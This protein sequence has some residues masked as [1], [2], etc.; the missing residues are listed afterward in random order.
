MNSIDLSWQM[1]RLTIW[2]DAQKDDPGLV[3]RHLSH[4]PFEDCY[5]TINP[6][7]QSPYPSANPNN[8]HLRGCAEGDTGANIEAAIALF[9][10]HGVQRFF[11]RLSPGPK[12]ETMR[13]CLRDHGMQRF[14]GTGYP[15][16]IRE[17]DEPASYQTAFNVRELSASD[18]SALTDALDQTIG[19]DQRRTFLSTVSKPG[20]YHFA[21]FEDALPVAVGVLCVLGEMGYLTNGA[22][23][24]RYRRQGAQ[25]ALIAHRIEKA[26]ALGC[27]YFVSQ[28]LYMLTSSLH[29]LQ[30]AGFREIYAEEVYEPKR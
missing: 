30:R 21:A 6:A 26:K 19:Q 13:Q 27:S 1:K 15:T 8:L 23:G 24:E 25:Q 5:L 3:R 4:P 16:L 22:T 9:R 2:L 29:N 17:T 28:T 10:E 11:V 18:M 14:G 20:F 7:K 12:M